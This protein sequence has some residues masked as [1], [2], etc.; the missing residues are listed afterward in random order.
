MFFIAKLTYNPAY[1]DIEEKHI[2]HETEAFIK[3]IWVFFALSWFTIFLVKYGFLA[4]FR[5]LV[6]RLPR[7]HHFWKGVVVVTTVAMA[8]NICGGFV[9]CPQFGLAARQ[10]LQCYCIWNSRLISR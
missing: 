10:S 5:S 3:F 8:F 9:T 2:S 4:Y 7:E 6:D 1:G